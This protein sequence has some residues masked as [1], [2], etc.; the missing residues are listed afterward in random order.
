MNTSITIR[1]R[2]VIIFF[3]LAC[4]LFSLMIRLAWIQFVRGEE[5]QEKALEMRLREVTVEAKRGII[6]DRKGRKLAVSA[7]A[8]SIYAVPPE[9]KRS[10]REKEIARQV[11]AVLEISPEELE[12]KI[13]ANRAFVWIKRKVEAEKARKIKELDLPGIETVEESRRYYPKG[14]LAAHILGFVGIDNQGLE[15]LEFTYDKV[16]RGKPGRIVVEYDAAGREIPQAMRRYIPPENGYNLVLTIDE[17]I[18]YIV[19][20]ELDRIMNSETNPASA[21]IIVMDPRSGEI[22]ALGSRPVYDPNKY[23]EYPQSVWR[24]IAVSNT[25]EP[26]ST[27]KV[28]TA[29]TALEEGLVSPEERFY[30]PGYIKVGKEIIKCWRYP[31]AHGNQTFVEGVQNS[32]NPV[33]VTI[34]LRIEDKQSGLFYDYIKAFGFGQETGVDLPGEAKGIMIPLE[35]LKRINI[36]TIAMG[37]SIS[38]TPI[39]LISAVAAIANGGILYRPHLVRQITDQDGNIV[40]QFEP[41]PIRQVIS[42]ETA[43]ELASILE[44]VVSHGTGRNAYIPGYRA[45]GKT[46]TAQKAGPGGYQQGKYVASFVG[47]AP[48]D[49]PQLVVLVVIDEPKGYPYYGG[50]VAAPVFKRVMEDSLRYLGV[51]VRYDPNEREKISQPAMVEV[52]SVIRLPLDKAQK[53]LRAAGLKAVVEG[54]GSLVIDQTPKPLAK[55]A[56]G[57]TVIL[58]VGSGKEKEETV[59]PDV[60]GKRLRE[61]AQLME[62]LNL[63]INPL[64]YGEAVEQDPRPGAVVPRGTTVKVI[65]REIETEKVL[66]P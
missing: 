54:N 25:Y 4:V 49:D 19:E 62:A 11:A 63:R 40:K 57:T 16:L 10:G 65:F 31:R 14:T 9:I 12:K 48:A 2:I 27:F 5:L 39:Q 8:D 29:A 53:A 33:F 13:T 7:S 56:E 43:R 55:V 46:G 36:A 42:R 37:Q 22:L 18:Q 1:K 47:F 3:L 15:G 32:C 58:Y 64:G 21:T 20:R 35:K 26:G 34:G 51:P 24:N 38:V 28:I 17:T 50:T 59:V 45:A 44:R 41:E 6:Y 52:P 61:A 60:T 23:G 30:D 66:G